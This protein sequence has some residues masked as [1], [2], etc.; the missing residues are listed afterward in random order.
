MEENKTLTAKPAFVISLKSV[1]T[2]LI[3]KG[4]LV[5]FKAEFICVFY[6]RKGTL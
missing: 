1:T 3:E 5:A 4:A 6:W 2:D